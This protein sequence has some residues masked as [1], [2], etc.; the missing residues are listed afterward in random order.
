MGMAKRLLQTTALLFGLGVM[1]SGPARAQADPTQLLP[2][3]GEEGVEVDF[4]RALDALLGPDDPSRAEGG[5]SPDDER[6]SGLFG[7]G[8]GCNGPVHAALVGP[9]GDVYLGGAFS[10]CGNVRA[11]GVVRFD[12]GLHRWHALGTGDGQGVDGEVH[13][14]ALDEGRLY[15][16]GRFRQVNAGAPVAASNIARWDGSTWTALGWGNGQGFNGPV[17]ALAVHQGRLFAGGDFTQANVGAAIRANR[18]ARWDGI[19]WQAVGNRSGNGLDAAVHALLSDRDGLLVG[20]AFS[21]ANLG[22]EVRA[23][24]V[25]RWHED[26]WLPLGDP[27]RNGV[28]GTVRALARVG[29]SIYLGG[30]FSNVYDE[31]GAP[32]HGLARW[33]GRSMQAVG[34]GLGNGLNNAVLALA[35]D[36]GVLYVGGRFTRANIGEDVDAMH[37]A[38]WDGRQ[39]RSLASANGTGMDRPVLAL[40]VAPAGLV[41]GGEFERSSGAGGMPASR[42]A[43]WRGFY[44]ALGRASG[45]MGSAGNIHALIMYRGMLHAGGDFRVIGGIAA[46]NLARWDGSAWQALESAGGNGVDGPVHALAVWD[47]RLH[48]GGRFDRAGGRTRADNLAAWDGHTW[49]AVGQGQGQG[50]N[51]SVYAL[52][53]G[54]AGLY[55]GGLF[56]LANIGES[57]P[58]GRVALWDGASWHA[59]GSEDGNGMDTAVYALAVDGEVLYAGGTFRQVN[60][61]GAVVRANRVARWQ[62]GRWSSLGN[63]AGNGLDS[64]V[65]ALAFHG[66]ELYVGGMFWQ[67]NVGEPVEAR[68]IARWDGSR[69]RTVGSGLD[70]PVLAL[71]AGSGELFAAGFFGRA[72]LAS[73]IRVNHVARWNGRSWS[74]LGSGTD[75]P[76]RAVLPD[77]GGVVY[78]AGSFSLAGGRP[79]ERIARFQAVQEGQGQSSSASDAPSSSAVSAR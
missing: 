57:L 33:T 48:V 2:G 61:G 62:D 59:L 45:G 23:S 22:A 79:S 4:S 58:V 52:A 55:V 75:R 40:A 53:A 65:Y 16:A 64:A 77:D 29:S 5:G 15:V 72:N 9:D 68:Y 7:L 32:A 46:N 26:E 44:D 31:E 47:D 21:R 66:G 25:A 30:G 19:A 6:W 70:N 74:G 28:N 20:G 13:A 78:V 8:Q 37:L 17:W 34:H 3:Y 71:A 56:T 14:L 24:R 12:P 51:D 69:W 60:H 27:D 63:G 54:D 43:L 36:D 50:M 41:V 39:W 11:G 73:F 38:A 10:A 1:S 76:V 35:V 42:V 67:A 49:F 18:I